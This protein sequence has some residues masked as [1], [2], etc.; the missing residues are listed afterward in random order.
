MTEQAHG[1]H[2]DE[3]AA[4]P[5]GDAA[6]APAD[7]SVVTDTDREL[8]NEAI[9]LATDNVAA[10]GGPFGAL[11]ARDGKVVAYGT[12]EVTQSLDPTAHAEVVAIRRACAALDDFRLTGC[13]LVSSCEPCPL[14]LSAA[15]WARVDRVIYAADRHEA[16]A[17]GF[18]DRTFHKLL[19]KP[20]KHWP[21]TV[22]QERTGK[23]GEPFS[24][25]RATPMRV[26][27]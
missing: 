5:S 1:R 22:A 12:N 10:G 8:L 11:V 7:D 17:A 9:R 19:C 27:Y 24:A 23:E 14:C 13:V 3:P 2:D 25:W 6:A 16:A 18:D 21:F 15:L 20:R 26:T 4:A